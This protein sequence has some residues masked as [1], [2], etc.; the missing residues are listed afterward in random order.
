MRYGQWG[1]HVEQINE[2]EVVT[3]ICLENAFWSS[4][5][6]IKLCLRETVFENVKWTK[7]L[8]H[9]QSAVTRQPGF[10]LVSVTG[11]SQLHKLWTENR[12]KYCIV[13][14]RGYVIGK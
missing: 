5:N 14:S 10:L 8:R 7:W 4:E 13:Y 2:T 3:Q 6:N 12:E 11:F 9:L 1:G